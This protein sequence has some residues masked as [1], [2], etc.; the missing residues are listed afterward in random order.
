MCRA[1]ILAIPCGN[2]AKF[3]L[4][5]VI[6]NYLLFGILKEQSIFAYI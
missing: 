4:L 5:Y 3:D 1:H 2:V 6:D